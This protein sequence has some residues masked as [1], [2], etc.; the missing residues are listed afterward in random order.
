VTLQVGTF[1]QHHRPSPPAPRHTRRRL[2]HPRPSLRSQKTSRFRMG[3]Q[4]P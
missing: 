1:E 2:P 3:P 4:R